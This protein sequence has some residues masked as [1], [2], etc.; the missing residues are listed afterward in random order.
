MTRH[1]AVFRLSVNIYE[2]LYRWSPA[3]GCMMPRANVDWDRLNHYR[4]N[5]L[6]KDFRFAW[7]DAGESLLLRRVHDA[8]AT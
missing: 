7:P 4:D 3:M 2:L 6:G 5:L 8:I 1:E